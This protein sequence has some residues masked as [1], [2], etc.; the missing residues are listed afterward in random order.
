MLSWE[1]QRAV[2]REA[3]T[4]WVAPSGAKHRIDYLRDA[5]PTV[6]LRLQEAFGTAE[7]PRIAGGAV[8]LIFELLTPAQRPAQVTQDLAGFW[9][10]SYQQVRPL[11]SLRTCCCGLSIA[12]GGSW[13]NPADKLPSLVADQSDLQRPCSQVKRELKGRYP[14][15]AWPDD[16]AVFE[17]TKTSSGGGAV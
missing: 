7:T 14:K 8:A 6:A 1:Q 12:M 3:P 15:H 4:H 17:Q 10:S 2:E 5:G 9:R 11:R 13:W 16:P